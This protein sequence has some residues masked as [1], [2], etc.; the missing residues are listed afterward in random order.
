V[1]TAA[2]YDACCDDDDGDTYCDYD[3]ILML[4][5]IVVMVVLVTMRMT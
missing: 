4:L 1:V 2:N 3:G 5:V